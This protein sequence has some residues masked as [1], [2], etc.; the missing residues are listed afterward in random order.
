MLSV[1]RVHLPSD[2]PIVGCE[3]TPYVL[4]RRPDKTVI[5][6]DVSESAPI[7][8]HFLRYKWYVPRLVNVFPIF[9]F[10]SFSFFSPLIRLHRFNY[11]L[12]MYFVLVNGIFLFL[13]LEC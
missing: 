7:D 1:L 3:L 10:L 6:D 9:S 8:G 12:F 4:L 11:R 13:V 2:I 5:N